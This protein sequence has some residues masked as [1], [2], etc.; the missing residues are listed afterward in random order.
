MVAEG[1]VAVT[2]VAAKVAERVGVET[3]GGMAEGARVVETEVEMEA[4][5]AVVD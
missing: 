4:V 3:V 2:A 1:M 5:M